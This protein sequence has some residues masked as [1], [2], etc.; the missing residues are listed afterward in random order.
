VISKTVGGVAPALVS[1]GTSNAV[2]AARAGTPAAEAAMVPVTERKDWR[3]V[4]STSISGNEPIL[5]G[6]TF[7]E[8]NRHRIDSWVINNRGTSKT[9]YLGNQSNGTEY[10]ASFTA[11]AGLTEVTLSTRFN[12]TTALWCN[13]NGTDQLVHTVTGHRIGSS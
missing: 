11:A 13:S 9:V 1:F 3:I 5:G 7:L 6:A 8:T 4:D 2:N 10:A 12:A